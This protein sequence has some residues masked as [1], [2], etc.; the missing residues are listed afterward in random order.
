[1][2]NFPIAH[3]ETRNKGLLTE[4]A[5][6]TTIDT[7]NVK[8]ERTFFVK[9]FITAS[10]NT[11]SSGGTAGDAATYELSG[12]FRDTAGTLAQ[13][14]STIK[15]ASEIDLAWDADFSVSGSTVLIR[16]TGEASTDIDWRCYSTVYK[17][18]G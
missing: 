11:S 14:G 18:K 2:A 9:S 3:P 7:I 5:T 4:D 13:I 17:D 16:V 1:M 12:A 10:R 15:T 8:T 6:V